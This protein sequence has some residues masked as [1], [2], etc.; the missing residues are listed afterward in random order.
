[1]SEPRFAYVASTYTSEELEERGGHG[2]RYNTLYLDPSEAV[3]ALFLSQWEK[4]DD[5]FVVNV[6]QVKLDE[7]EGMWP[8]ASNTFNDC[9]LLWSCSYRG[10][11][12]FNA[13]RWISR[14]RADHFVSRGMNRY[15]WS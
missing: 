13:L 9:D 11:I 6:Y 1:M 8:R 7:L 3:N 5:D 2:D 4:P 15:P 10:K 12:P 14:T